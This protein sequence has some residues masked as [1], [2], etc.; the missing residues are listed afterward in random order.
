MPDNPCDKIW[1]PGKKYC[2]QGL[3][4]GGGPPPS[5]P[6]DKYGLVGGA[7]KHVRDLAEELITAVKGLVAPDH[8]WVPKKPDSWVYEQFLWLGQHLAVA[9]FICVVVVC[10]LTAW[11]GVP[12]LRQM[13]MSLGWTLAAVAGM[14]AVPGAVELLNKAVNEAFTAA[15]NSGQGTL[16]NVIEDDLARANSIG[17]L[18][19]LFIV[20]A[21]V[22]ALA[23][24][25][26]VYMTRQPGILVFVCLAP[27]VLASLARGGDTTAV[28]RWANRLL[29]LIFCPFALLIV[30]P[31]VGLAKGNL[32]LDGA[33][34]VAA[35]V[36]M[37]RMIFH[38]VPYIGP[39]VARMARSMVEDRTQS[40]AVRGLMKAGVPDFSEEENT[41]RPPRTV[42]TPGRALTQDRDVL[43][44]AY[45]VNRPSRPGRPTIESAVAKA[46][47]P[48][49]AERYT[50][51][52]QARQQA[53]EQ[54]GA[55]TPQNSAAPRTA[56]PRTA[57]PRPPANRPTPPQRPAS[58]PTP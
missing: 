39:R 16:F 18:G 52:M 42:A 40:V 12:R 21:L 58:P 50:R 47:A 5:D 30:T 38:G 45:G 43:F 7:S 28:W 2:E 32:I 36:I 27:L 15:F 33:L 19:S 24:A 57:A 54:A 11:Q 1:G 34:L 9:I 46:Q 6:T 53:R 55:T 51:I 13:G 4:D 10:G 22:V 37:L 23:F 48:K 56:A 8:T 17:P 20:S 25:A 31:F 49:D 35:D 41:P 44:A 3:H 29:G 14:A 26:L